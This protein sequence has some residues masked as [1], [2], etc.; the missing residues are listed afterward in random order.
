VAPLARIVAATFGVVVLLGIYCWLGSAWLP[1]YFPALSLHLA[2]GLA[3]LVAG[4]PVLAWHIGRTRAPVGPALLLPAI[5]LGVVAA[6]VPGRPEYP[7]FGPVGWGCATTAVHLLVVAALV[8]LF[9]RDAPPPPAARRTG[10]G[11]LLG[12]V[13]LVAMHVGVFGWL[14]R[15]D[16]RW[17]AMAAHSALGLLTLLVLLPHLGAV[18]R[19]V[20]A[21][22][23]VPLLL[24]AIAGLGRVWIADYPHDL[25]LGDFRSPLEFGDLYLVPEVLAD[26][27]PR[28]IAPQTR[29]ERLSPP[30]P[31]L[32]EAL[33]GDSRRCGADGCHETLTR[34]WSGSI[35]RFATDNAIFLKVVGQLVE[36][37]GPEEAAFC[38]TCHDPVRALA[39][40][41]ADAY[42]HGDPPPGD[43]VS[44]VVCHSTID[45]SDDPF[46][47][48]MLVREPRPYPGR[49]EAQRN[50]R[51]RLDPRAHR[52]Q[53]TVNFRIADSNRGCA[54]CHRFVIGPDIGATLVGDVPLP[55]K[56]RPDG[57]PDPD[58]LD[59]NDCHM[60]TLTTVRPFEQAVYDHFWPGTAL[61]LP[62]Y[63][64]HGPDSAAALAAAAD[65]TLRFLG[66]RLSTAGLA[67]SVAYNRPRATVE[68]LEETG[69]LAMSV[70]A[71][72]ID[73]VLGVA[74]RTSKH[75]SGHDFPTG[76]LDIKE[77]W[78][79]IV[80]LDATGAT[81]AHLG[82]LDERLRVDPAAHRL[83]AVYW[84]DQGL[85]L[86]HHRVWVLSEVTDV[87]RVPVG[88]SIED[89]YEFAVPPES[90]GPFT[91]RAA[92]KH[93]RINA[94]F[95]EWVFG[96]AG[97]FP[98]HEIASATAEVE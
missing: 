63:A 73:G 89:L 75:R 50:R 46:N 22:V 53:F 11:A 72:R 1:G 26:E 33:M 21:L 64:N 24:L 51:I 38:A 27:Q 55:F 25:L 2:L 83:G 12:L 67:D 39:G 49:T 6:V 62:R 59:C 30:G 94:E 98:V 82:A 95:A 76:S 48:N 96:D 60:P 13:P 81:V 54:P 61:D 79:E 23:G 78:Q 87:R 14:M 91:V 69:L 16:E 84:D 71:R 97:R 28:A 8:P 34:Q 70:V 42:A 9:R 88:G 66:G 7:A 20:P 5:L 18:R 74:V 32:D 58:A 40:T 93:R 29:A 90:P 45:V 10:S 44:C 47:G 15:G 36:E 37:K 92:W 52:R 17:G 85:P 68:A 4:T 19:R 31:F 35:H 3:V 41:V 65:Q 80:V 56:R 77:F 57:R 43:G 86:T